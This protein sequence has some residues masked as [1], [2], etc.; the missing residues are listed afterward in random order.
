LKRRTS[1]SRNKL[2]RSGLNIFSR[3]HSKADKAA[4][5]IMAAVV[6]MVVRVSK[7]AVVNTVRA[8]ASTRVAVTSEAAVETGQIS[9]TV[10]LRAVEIATYHASLKRSTKKRS[11][12]KYAKHRLNFLVVKAAIRV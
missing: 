11:R 9:A 10:V 12:I 5:V 6:I 8:E 4:A 2:R 3:N 1:S 7:V